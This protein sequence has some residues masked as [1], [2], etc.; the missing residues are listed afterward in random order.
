VILNLDRFV[1]VRLG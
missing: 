1:S